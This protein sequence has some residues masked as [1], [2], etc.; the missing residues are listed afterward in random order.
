VAKQPPFNFGGLSWRDR[1]QLVNSVLFCV[2][3][4][5][6]IVRSVRGGVPWAALL[7]G[8]L[9]LAFGVYRLSLARREL[10][11]RNHE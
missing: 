8:G 3:G 4:G 9:F 11:K 1:I 5:V 10:R 7:L 2:L 6:L